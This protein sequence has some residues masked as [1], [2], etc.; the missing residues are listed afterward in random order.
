MHKVAKVLVMLFGVVW[1]NSPS[2][3]D[4]S[5][6]RYANDGTHQYQYRDTMDRIYF[7]PEVGYV[8]PTDSKVDDTVFVGGRLGY[9]F[10]ENWAIEAESGWMRF[11]YE[12]DK[13]RG[14][15]ED[16]DIDS[17]PIMGNVRYT[18]TRCEDDKFDWYVFG[19]VGAN[20]NNIQSN[21]LGVSL[22]NSVA[23][24]A[25]LGADYFVTDRT[26]LF[27]DARYLW[28]N[29]NVSADNS[30]LDEA[31]D[32]ENVDVDLKSVMFTGGVKF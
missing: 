6:H 25:G 22:D 26:T 18:G 24:Q 17:V 13:V 20:I 31:L 21:Q 30:R 5:T 8:L 23:W 11:E 4:D 7:A 12:V 32:R 15:H 3:A 9:N 1:I 28:N 29:P 10:D 14:G 27:L 19:G 2:L 16:I